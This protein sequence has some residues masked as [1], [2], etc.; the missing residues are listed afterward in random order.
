MNPHTPKGT[1]MLGIGVPKGLPNFQS[2]IIGVKTYHLED[3][4]ISLE[5][6]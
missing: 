1:P 5:I 4:L 6:Y 3:F 2:A